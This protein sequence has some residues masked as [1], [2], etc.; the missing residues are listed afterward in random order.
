MFIVRRKRTSG[1]YPAV[2]PGFAGI[3]RSQIASSFSR[4]VDKI[5]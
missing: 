4:P 3:A 1:D 2:L 5:G